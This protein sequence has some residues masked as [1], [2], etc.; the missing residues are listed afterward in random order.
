MPEEVKPPYI[1]DKDQMALRPATEQEVAKEPER[2]ETI[3]DAQEVHGPQENIP[4]EK[5]STS[6]AEARRQAGTQ[7]PPAK[8]AGVQETPKPA[9]VAA[10]PK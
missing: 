10:K 3:H 9:A 1:Y 8:Q 7:A 2:L 4:P 5:V 6:F